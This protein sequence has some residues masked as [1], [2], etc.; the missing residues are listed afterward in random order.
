MPRLLKTHRVLRHAIVLPMT[1][2]LVVAHYGLAAE[3][4]PGSQAAMSAVVDT[5]AV[6]MP[7]V[8]TPLI[9]KTGKSKP[10]STE[11]K[12]VEAQARTSANAGQEEQLPEQTES[13]SSKKAWIY[14]GLGVAAAA[15]IVA[16]AA[17][18]GGGGGGSTPDNG[19]NSNGSGDCH[20]ETPVNKN[21]RS[22]VANNPNATPLCADLSGP[23]S[24]RLDL[25]NDDS[26]PVTASIDQDGGKIQI[27]TS[28]GKPYGKLFIGEVDA[29]CKFNVYDQT[30]GEL[31]STHFGAATAG[32]IAIYDYVDTSCYG[33]TKYDSLILTR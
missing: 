20:E 2:S 9:E 3:N 32:R 14:G 27:T 1:L 23:W 7:A 18:G 21:P 13:S 12:P 19:N 24:G 26:I 28:S 10:P 31:W 15:A 30:T 11:I 5:P 22:P 4:T 29:N 33:N 6:D 16:V 8:D 17:G 25:A